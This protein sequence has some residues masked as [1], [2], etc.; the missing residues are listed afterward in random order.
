MYN[1]DVCHTGSQRQR[2]TSQTFYFTTCD[3]P[4]SQNTHLQISTIN[5]KSKNVYI[6][7]VY[8]E[9]TL[10][11]IC[12]SSS[13]KYQNDLVQ[14]SS[15]YSNQFISRIHSKKKRVCGYPE[16]AIQF[17][18]KQAEKRLLRRDLTLVPRYT[19]PSPQIKN[20]GSAMLTC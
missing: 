14:F 12:N 5:S 4:T 18:S 2:G 6:A 17:L 10:C 20:I 1:T 7:L 3:K 8:N 15:Q 13:N 9:T 19:H 16:S 11:L